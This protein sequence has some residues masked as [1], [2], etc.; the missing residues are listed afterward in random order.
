[1]YFAVITQNLVACRRRASSF[2]LRCSS[3]GIE[4]QSTM[5][6]NKVPRRFAKQGPPGDTQFI[7][8]KGA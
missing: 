3:N 7:W 2:T 6:R 1:M 4:D 8:R 5:S